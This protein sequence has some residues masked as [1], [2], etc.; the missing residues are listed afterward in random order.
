MNI[1]FFYNHNIGIVLYSNVNMN[2]LGLFLFS[3][4]KFKITVFSVQCP[5]TIS[6]KEIHIY[7]VYIVVD[8]IYDGMIE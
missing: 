1:I 6:P 8:R 2:L 5:L 7:E 3:K 4:C